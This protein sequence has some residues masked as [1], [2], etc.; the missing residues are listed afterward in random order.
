MYAAY[1]AEA[2]TKQEDIH[3]N[4][5]TGCITCGETA[6]ST[7]ANVRDAKKAWFEVALEEGVDIPK[8]DSLR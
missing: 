4:G 5:K 6:E 2:R 3:K 7:V 8:P 1:H